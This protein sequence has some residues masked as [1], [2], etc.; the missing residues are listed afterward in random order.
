MQPAQ[1]VNCA[2]PHLNP[3]PRTAAPTR[4]PPPR[5]PRPPALRVGLLYVE[6]GERN[7]GQRLRLAA[8]A[9]LGERDAHSGEEALDGC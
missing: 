4:H 6:V 2:P 3:K 9:Q 1:L 5:P 8:L 7:V